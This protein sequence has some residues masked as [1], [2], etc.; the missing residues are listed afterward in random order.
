MRVRPAQKQKL[1]SQKIL[2][3]CCALVFSLGALAGARH[4]FAQN[5]GTDYASFFTE[6]V[7]TVDRERDGILPGTLRTALVQAGGILAKNN[8]TI[9]KIVFA[10]QVKR[11]QITKGLLPE[12]DGSLMTIDCRAHQ[13]K[14]VI[15]WASQ[16]EAGE[17]PGEER[18]GFKI[19]GNGNTVRGCHLTGFPA[20]GILIT[21][22]RNVIEDNVL[23]YHK[24]VP[25]TAV[26][27]SSLYQEPKTNGRAGIQLAKGANENKIRHNDIVGNTFHGIF[28]EEGVGTANEISYNFFSKNS[29]QAI[30]AMP[31]G[32]KTQ[33]PTLQRITQNGGTYLIEGTTP[34][35]STVQIYQAGGGSDE[36][37]ML[38]KEEKQYQSDKFT[39]T[40]EDRG[41]VPNETQLVVLAQALGKNTS[42]F[43]TPVLVSG[44]PANP[45]PAEIQ[46]QAPTPEPAPA[47]KEL[48]SPPQSAP[49]EKPD[50]I[51]DVQGQGEDGGE[52][53][54]TADEPRQ[55]ETSAL[56]I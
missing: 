53:D 35:R 32:N 4:G 13:E 43:S 40:I 52:P 45:P 55:N 5:S 26:E 24:E 2:R 18:V 39:I 54:G 11:I 6:E 22:N 3:I 27:A 15:E 14:V 17:D 30:K 10:P 41:I 49:E 8:F 23:G 56:G 50:V 44:P 20:S 9:V 46:V 7:L 33:T 37:G 36:V 42:E 34:P 19:S 12:I 47:E 25:E 38:V 28:I 21:G 31:S 16:V 48:S 51:I 1:S 29:G